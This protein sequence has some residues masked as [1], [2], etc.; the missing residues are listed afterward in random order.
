MVLTRLCPG[1]AGVRM[2]GWGFSL[3]FRKTGIGSQHL[4]WGTHRCPYL[5]VLLLA[6]VGTLTD[7]DTDTLAS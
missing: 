5:P 4:C 2:G 3:L 6:T 1:A 7:T